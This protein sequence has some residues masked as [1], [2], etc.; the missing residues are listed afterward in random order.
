MVR[1]KAL[2]EFVL[3][4]KTATL[5]AF[6]PIRRSDNADI[7]GYAERKDFLIIPARLRK[8]KLKFKE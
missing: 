6:G 2:L 1:N 7:A 4:L 8:K 5:R 3:C